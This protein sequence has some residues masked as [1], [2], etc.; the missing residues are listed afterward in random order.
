MKSSELYE[1]LHSMPKCVP[2]NYGNRILLTATFQLSKEDVIKMLKCDI[3]KL[4][5]RYYRAPYKEL[6]EMQLNNNYDTIEL[7]LEQINP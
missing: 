4:G 6:K 1:H 5:D 7:T 2:I 3:V